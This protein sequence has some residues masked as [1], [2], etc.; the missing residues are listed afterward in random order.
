MRAKS[1]DALCECG[2]AARWH[3]CSI[4]RDGGAFYGECL[5]YGCNESGGMRWSKWR[6][7]WVDHCHGFR[8]AQPNMEES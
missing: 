7:K 4:T 5:T 6:R 3:H 8:E 2:C 1:P